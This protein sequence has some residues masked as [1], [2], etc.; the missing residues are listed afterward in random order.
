MRQDIQSHRGFRNIYIRKEKCGI[1]HERM[2]SSMGRQKEI[3]LSWWSCISVINNNK[4]VIKDI[5][6]KKKKKGRKKSKGHSKRKRTRTWAKGT[7]S[8][9]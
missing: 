8:Y 1:Q 9:I 6:Q 2:N 5:L 7:N 3:N 4:R